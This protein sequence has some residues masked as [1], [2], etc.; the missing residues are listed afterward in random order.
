VPDPDA[1]LEGVRREVTAASAWLVGLARR[2]PEAPELDATVAHAAFGELNCKAWLAFIELHDGIHAAQVQALHDTAPVPKVIPTEGVTRERLEAAAAHDFVDLWPAVAARRA[3]LLESLAGLDE[4]QAR[5]RPGKG[6]GE[7]AWSAV[8]VAQHLA[9][10]SRNVS[11]VVAALAQGQTET[12]LPPGYIEPNLEA[13]LGSV[14]SDLT[15]AS[16][17]FLSVIERLPAEPD[18]EAIV[19][20]RAHGPLNCR[21]WFAMASIHDLDHTRQV[22]TL[23]QA[24]G[25][26]Q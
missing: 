8:E 23:R 17:Q 6:E 2:L 12:K 24:E 1:T 9:I 20:H 18:L 3:A 25:F 13:P 16:A 21:M 4:T 15:A 22:E 5:W 11:D 26:P 19:A 7:E 10:W 14:R